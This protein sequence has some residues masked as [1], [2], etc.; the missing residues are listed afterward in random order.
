MLIRVL[1][2]TEEK[3]ETFIALSDFDV[4]DK[5]KY[6]IPEDSVVYIY[7]TD[8]RGFPVKL[9]DELKLSDIFNL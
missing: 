9:I 6:N 2:K 1:Y 5:I 8:T 4:L 3:G 7:E